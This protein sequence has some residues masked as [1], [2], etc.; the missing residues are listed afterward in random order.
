MGTQKQYEQET[1]INFNRADDTAS[2]YTHEVRWQHY[3]EACGIPGVDYGDGAKEYQIPRKWVK[4]PRR[5]APVSEAR[6]EAGRR[7]AAHQRK[8]PS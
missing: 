5:P 2:V 4:M 7:L 6:R 3:L 8:A 1:I